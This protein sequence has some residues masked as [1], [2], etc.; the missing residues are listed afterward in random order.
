[1]LKDTDSVDADN[2]LGVTYKDAT[3]TAAHIEYAI[4]S[5][6]GKGFE[7]YA[8]CAEFAKAYHLDTVVFMRS[9][10]DYRYVTHLGDAVTRTAWM[11]AYREV[12]YWTEEDEKGNDKQFFFA[13]DSYAHMRACR[14][15]GEETDGKYPPLY[16]RNYF[17]PT[18]FFDEVSATFNVAKPI[19][20]FAADTGADTSGIHT[21]L[22]HLAGECYPH[23]LMWLRAKMVHP[24]RKT[25]VI[26]IFVGAQGTGKST[27]GECICTALFGR[28]NVLV[29]DQFDSTARFNTDNA[30]ALIVC[31]EEKTQD[32]KRNTSGN[33]KSR[34]TASRVRKEAKG[35]DPIFQ[36]AHTDY[37]LTTNEVVPLKFDDRGNQRRFMVMEVDAEFTR[38]KSQ[39]ADAVFTQLYGV[40]GKGEAVGTGLARATE[41]I[42]QFKMDLWRKKNCDGVN[43]KEF[44]HT[45]AYDRC[46][47]VPRTNEAVE[48]E[49]IIRSLVPFI[50]ASLT[51][52]YVLPK[53]DVEHD[54]ETIPV[55][56]DRICDEV[57]MQY[58][59]KTPV[60]PS[61]IA[62]C[63]QEVFK[64]RE[65]GKHYAHSV[66]ERVLLDMKT[67]FL[68]EGLVLHGDTTP[69][70]G[71]TGFRNILG[72]SRHSPAAWFSL[73]TTEER[74][75]GPILNP[76]I[77]D[78][79]ATD[80][81]EEGSKMRVG[82]RVPFN[83]SF[84]Y[85]EE[86]EFETLNELK[87][88][89]L[90]RTKENAQYLDTFL[91]EADETSPSIEEY[92]A[93]KL[94]SAGKHESYWSAEILYDKRLKMQDVEAERL[95]QAGIACRVVYSGAKS[96]HILVR[97]EHSPTT[98]EERNWLDAYLKATLSDK[99]SFDMSTRDPTRLTRAP[100]TKERCTLVPDYD[101]KYKYDRGKKV[102][103]TQRLLAENWGNV[104]QLD[105]RPMYQ[106][107][108]DMPPSR[109]EQ[110]GR[111]VPTKELYKNAG[112]ALLTGTFFTDRQWDGCRQTTFFPAYRLLRAMGYSH[113][114]LWLEIGTQ[115]SG[116]RKK[117]E[118]HYWH[119]RKTC[120]LIR[121]ID[122][123]VDALLQDK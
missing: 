37:V 65:T 58:V 10:G 78:M 86:G 7:N 1:V 92:E 109:Y 30:D 32:D 67:W 72:K 43:Y 34:A 33:L 26:P 111:M 118:V 112:I 31:I 89:R 79:E 19:T 70:S 47:S 80:P 77:L 61:R 114:E 106:A 51:A 75:D 9:H 69:P 71:V 105:W 55:Y 116:Y 113:D 56:L 12:L 117:A 84:N 52:G 16:R 102:I 121:K 83:A 38:Q 68:T 48:V 41:R 94:W 2:V 63:R 13:P 123:D 49:S 22:K 29:T 40:D 36:E 82:R 50:R 44:P 24:E 76:Y 100:I 28:D 59:R 18:G 27:F 57:A 115:L 46:F 14:I 6:V 81:V 45:E 17:V 91:L 23:L 87:P 54:G 104:Y 21:L 98:L 85:D 42:A 107:W 3:D 15:Y 110:R 53:I 108:L 88:G 93:H 35:V 97:V 122:E 39:L 11:L 95:M 66:V 119:T 73:Y 64:D 99:L 20:T 5:H 96:L 8:Q 103:G 120:A 90:E 60:M 25:E 101:T 62:L 4:S 74:N